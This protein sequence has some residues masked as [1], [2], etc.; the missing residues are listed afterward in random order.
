M[1]FGGDCG[2]VTL[3]FMWRL[4]RCVDAMV[5]LLLLTFVKPVVTVTCRSKISLIKEIKKNIR[6]TPREQLFRETCLGD[7]IKI[8]FGRKKFCLV[9]GLRFG[10]DYSSLY[11]AGLIPFR[12]RV[13][14]SARDGHPIT[15]KISLKD[16]NMRHWP[17]FY[18]TPV[19]ED[20]D[21]HKYMLH[22]FTWAFKGARPTPDP[23]EA[24]SDWLVSSRG[25]FDDRIHEPPRIS[26]LVNLHRRD[27]PEVYMYRQC[28]ESGK[29]ESIYEFSKYCRTKKRSDKSKNMARNAKVPN[30][31]LGNMVVD[32]NLVD[33]EVVITGAHDTDEY[34][35]YTNVDPNK[36]RL[37]RYEECM[38]FLNKCHPI[39]LDC[40]VKGYKAMEVFWRILVAII[41]W[42]SLK[43]RVGCRTT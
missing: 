6:N 39:F 32:D 14:D 1:H 42:I 10:V 2:V 15:A 35:W 20:G 18:A 22:N 13:F 8:Q 26:S 4:C 17:V 27:D 30:F 19:E 28:N 16:A 7:D 31:D 38:I 12:R 34:I 23:F 29:N 43:K 36:V 21:K 3:L 9:T 37:E 5:V 11:S 24:R 40:H 33:D 25:F 41:I